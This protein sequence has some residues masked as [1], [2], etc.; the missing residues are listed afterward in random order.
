MPRTWRGTSNTTSTS[1][2]YRPGQGALDYG[3]YLK[4]LAALPRETP[5]M[6]EHLD[7]PADY[8][9][10]RAHVLQECRKAGVAV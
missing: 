4:R 5:L 9:L 8:D 6:L 1:G 2:R 10:A 7:G 3:T